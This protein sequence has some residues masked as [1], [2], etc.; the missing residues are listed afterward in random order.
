MKIVKF[1]CLTLAI[2]SLFLLID[3]NTQL[4]VG[5]LLTVVVILYEIVF[6]EK[7]KFEKLCEELDGAEDAYFHV[8]VSIYPDWDKLSPLLQRQNI[9][10]NTNK[11]EWERIIDDFENIGYL[12]KG[13]NCLHIIYK[14]GLLMHPYSSQQKVIFC[15]DKD[16]GSMEDVQFF[17][18]YLK[19]NGAIICK[20]C[21]DGNPLLSADYE[22]NICTI[23]SIMLDKVVKI[24]Y[25]KSRPSKYAIDPEIDLDNSICKNW[26]VTKKSCYDALFECDY[27]NV[28]IQISKK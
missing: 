6:A 8:T 21:F 23:I 14:S 15:Y 26:E 3:K 17:N 19:F 5:I 22:L 18:R 1:L 24:E 11:I 13:Q 12:M 4:A 27:L 25:L 16:V 2:L 10:P 20:F 28:H 7:T 9:D